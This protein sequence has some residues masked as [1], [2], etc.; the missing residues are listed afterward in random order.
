MAAQEAEAAEHFRRWLEAE[1]HISP[2]A[3]LDRFKAA[4]FHLTWIPWLVFGWMFY[5]WPFF[6]F[7][8]AQVPTLVLCVVGL[9]WP[10]EIVLMLLAALSA[11]LARRH[12]YERLLRS[13]KRDA[14]Q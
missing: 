2:K 12:V 14:G 7:F 4:S 11:A 13:E 6:H 9:V 3:Q 1:Q 5:R 8:I 10:V